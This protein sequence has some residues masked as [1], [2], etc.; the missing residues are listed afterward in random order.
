MMTVAEKL[1]AEARRRSDTTL[2]SK[3]VPADRRIS[4]E[5]LDMMR[6]ELKIRDLE[7]KK[8]RGE[9]LWI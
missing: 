6:R 4:I 7:N 9:P 8:L 2:Y 5:E 3:P 1:E